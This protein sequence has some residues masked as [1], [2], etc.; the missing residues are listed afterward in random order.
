M[1]LLF[2]KKIHA[3]VIGSQ[4]TDMFHRSVIKDQYNDVLVYPY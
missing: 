3:E 1:L 2:G 4:N